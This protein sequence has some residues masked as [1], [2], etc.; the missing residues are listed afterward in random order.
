MIPGW[1]LCTGPFIYTFALLLDRPRLD[2]I[3][4]LIDGQT[5]SLVYFTHRWYFS[6]FFFLFLNLKYFWMGKGTPDCSHQV[7]YICYCA[8]LVGMFFLWME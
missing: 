5:H 6:Y 8:G 7:Y 2:S 3:G 1:S 4:R